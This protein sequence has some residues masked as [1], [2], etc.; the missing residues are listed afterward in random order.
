M[1]RYLHWPKAPPPVTWAEVPIRRDSVFIDIGPGSHR[2]GV[3][4]VLR[5]NQQYVRFYK[6]G[7]TYTNIEI[8]LN[9]GTSWTYLYPDNPSLSQHVF[10]WSTPPSSISN[11]PVWIRWNTVGI[12][13][14]RTLKFTLAVIEPATR[15]FIS[16]DWIAL[17][18]GGPTGGAV[19]RHSQMFLWT[20]ATTPYQQMDRPLLVVEGIDA[21]NINSANSYYGLGSSPEDVEPV[22]STLFQQALNLNADLL[23]LDF[24][25]GGRGMAH[26]A[27]VVEGA[28]GLVRGLRSEPSRGFDLAGVSMGGV[29]A[30]YALARMEGAGV[31]HSVAPFVS[32]D[33]P[34]RGAVVD[35][36]LQEEIRDR[37][38]EVPAGFT[39]QAGKQLL[40]ENVFDTG[41]PKRHTLFYDSLR[42]LNGGLGYPVQSENIGVSF[43]SSQLN[44]TLQVWVYI[45]KPFGNI[46]FPING[47]IRQAGSYL[48]RDQARNWGHAGIPG[49]ST[50]MG[51]LGLEWNIF[52]YELIRSGTYNPTFIPQANALDI[53]D[54][55]VCPGVSC[56]TSAFGANVLYPS[57]TTF[58][59]VVP[60]VI[61]RALVSRLG[62]RTPPPPQ[63]AFASTVT[64]PYS[65]PSGTVTWTASVNRYPS[66]GTS[67]VWEYRIILPGSSCGID[68]GDLQRT[69]SGSAKKP[70]GETNIVP[71]CVWYA[72]GSGATFSYYADNNYYLDLRVTATKGTETHTTQRRVTIGSP[73]PPGG[74]DGP[75]DSHE[76]ASLLEVAPAVAFGFQSLSP[77]PSRLG[78]EIRVRYGLPEAA[79]VRLVLYDLLGRERWSLSLASS[80]GFSEVVVPTD[81]LSAGSYMLTLE[82]DGQRQ[83]RRLIVH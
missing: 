51:W 74:G 77:S 4:Y 61:T 17:N 2:N 72:G 50:V 53:A 10:D 28:I 13:D 55:G 68:D 41:F 22:D 54:G 19:I 23:I 82:A 30:R 8:S 76:S 11:H 46:F 70:G 7:N 63:P 78:T 25:D 39:S 6:A 79:P 49:L 3:T 62:Y 56:S 24:A 60:L 80:S 42:A 15:R 36:A 14:K 34:Q 29:V 57:V 81:G 45:D 71:Q 31:P 67:Y 66:T 5:S 26:N 9:E 38:V 37:G 32:L 40:V 65:V 18:K 20:R 33:A 64:G 1:Q 58:H 48:P 83:S 75:L 35:K 21:D 47:L 44:A 27:R 52:S 73:S 43:G 69:A 16:N 12:P 59:D